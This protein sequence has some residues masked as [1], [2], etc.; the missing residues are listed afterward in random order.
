MR[1]G[2]SLWGVTLPCI[3]GVFGKDG[4]GSNLNVQNSWANEALA[5]VVQFEVLRLAA[6]NRE[7]GIYLQSTASRSREIAIYIQEIA[8]DIEG[9]G[10]YIKEIAAA[11]RETGINWSEIATYIQE[12]A[13]NIGE[14][15]I[16]IRRTA[17]RSSKLR[18]RRPLERMEAASLIQRH[19]VRL[20]FIHL[21]QSRLLGGEVAIQDVEI[22]FVVQ[23]DRS[24]IEIS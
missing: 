24:V 3:L 14:I 6:R 12:M 16:C 17:G 20:L 15:H 11:S 9:I 19:F 4:S 22:G 7:T 8:A 13:A 18:I 2:P 21:E 23:L 5:V 10:I 1:A